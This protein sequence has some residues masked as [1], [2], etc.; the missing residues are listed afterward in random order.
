MQTL[1]RLYKAILDHEKV[2]LH[3][4]LYKLVKSLFASVEHMKYAHHGH[5]LEARGCILRRLR[6]M[7]AWG[8]RTYYYAMIHDN[9]INGIKTDFRIKISCFNAI[10]WYEFTS[11]HYW[12]MKIA[13]RLTKAFLNAFGLS[14]P[15]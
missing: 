7:F 11:V 4:I 6:L 2:C 10:K 15:S 13:M 9:Q 3:T 12:N 5:S 14:M 1:C 8:N